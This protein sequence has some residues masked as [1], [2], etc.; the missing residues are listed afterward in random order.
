VH[1]KHLKG[2]FGILRKLTT[3]QLDH[4]KEY[5]AQRQIEKYRGK[6]VPAPPSKRNLPLS[7]KSGSGRNATEKFKA[8][9]L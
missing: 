5:L 8:P 4:V 7:V 2:H 3:I 1:I 6:Y 9:A